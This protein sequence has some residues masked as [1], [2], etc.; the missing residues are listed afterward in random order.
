MFQMY[1]ETFI[2]GRLGDT[3]VMGEEDDMEDAGA[4]QA[5][6]SQ[7]EAMVTTRPHR[8]NGKTFGSGPPLIGR[9]GS[10]SAM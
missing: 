1:D 2:V 7:T 10:R 3:G 6:T 8:L 9:N 4:E 5:A